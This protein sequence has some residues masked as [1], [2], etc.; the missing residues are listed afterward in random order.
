M[1]KQV[2]Y[3]RQVSPHLED[4]YGAE[5]ANAIMEKALKRYGE[6]ISEN[7]DEPREY[8]M[9]TR[10]RIYPS[11]AVFDALLDEGVKRSEAEAFVTDYYRWRAQGMASK[12]KA[13]F[14]IPGL[15]RIVPKFFFNLTQKSFGPEAGFSSENQHLGKGEMHFDMTRCPYHEKCV[16]YGCPEIVKGFCDAD[17]IC[18]GNMHPKIS[19]DRTKTIGHGYD[20]C[21]FKVHIKEK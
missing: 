10:E 17:D 8:Y 18:Y 20:V 7:K 15:Y 12:I 13:V 21:D 14:K 11:V 16:H 5:R 1:A 4:K 6:L 9:H 19:W 3:L 2:R